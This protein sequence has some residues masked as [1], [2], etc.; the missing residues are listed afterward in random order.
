MLC[1]KNREKFQILHS[2]INEILGRTGRSYY[3]PGQ[4]HGLHPKQRFFEAN[5]SSA[6]QNFS[7]LF[8]TAW[9]SLGFMEAISWY[10]KKPVYKQLK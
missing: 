2:N 9:I 7:P 1:S 3:I 8:E 4:R 6:V 5:S 10:K